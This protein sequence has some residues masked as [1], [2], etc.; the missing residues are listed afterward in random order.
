MFV[1]EALITHRA[2]GTDIGVASIFHSF[3]WRW[4]VC[5]RVGVQYLLIYFKH[6]VFFFPWLIIRFLSIVFSKCGLG[7][8]DFA[9]SVTMREYILVCIVRFAAMK[10]ILK[11]ASVRF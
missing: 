10:S 7:T 6:P 2:A 1:S 9:S 4:M 3:G 5:C 11:Y 8:G